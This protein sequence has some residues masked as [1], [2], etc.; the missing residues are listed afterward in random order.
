MIKCLSIRKG[1]LAWLVGMTPL[2]SQAQTMGACHKS[3]AHPFRFF[4]FS[5]IRN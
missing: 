5:Q 2:A 4:S 1:L 3:M